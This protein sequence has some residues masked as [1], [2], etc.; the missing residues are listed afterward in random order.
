[1][2]RRFSFHSIAITLTLFAALSLPVPSYAD[3]VKAP[4]Y[5]SSPF[6]LINAVN[7]LRGSN[8][9]PAYSINS[10]LM[11]TAQSQAD[12]MA[13]TGN[14]THTGAGGSSVTGRLLAAGY[15]LAGDLSLGGFRSENIISGGESMTAQ[16]AVNAWTGDAPHL[17]TMLT[18]SLTEIG[19]GV[20]VTGGRVYYVIDA[21]LPTTG[22]GQP[23]VA[24]A[25]VVDGTVVSAVGGV[26][27]P[28][29]IST[30]DADGN[31]IHE[32]LAGQSLWQIAIDYEV[33][34]DDI[35][36]LNNL[37]SNDIYPGEKL[38]IKKEALA[39]TQTPAEIAMIEATVSP[40]LTSVPAS[41]L[42]QATFTITPTHIPRPAANNNTR[43]MGAVLGILAIALVGGGI[44]TWLG[45]SK[46]I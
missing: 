29:A 30:P 7:A 8:G 46:K 33:R 23:S 17:D 35:K 1:M 2:Y 28:V 6:D 31:V 24:T 19:A 32:V 22:V 41:T 43:V 21:A 27:I 36:R 3:A 4:P 16:D 20:T 26:I 14:V 40:T 12:Y 45:S 11:Y 25:V 39:I 18:P 42:V 9:L 38:L 10:I 5:A 13:A 15:P 44:F 37:S 34:I